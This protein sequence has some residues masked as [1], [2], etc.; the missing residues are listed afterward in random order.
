MQ[1]TKIVPHLPYCEGRFGSNRGHRAN[2][3]NAPFC[4]PMIQSR[5]TAL[6]AWPLWLPFR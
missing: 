5:P 1:W 2:Q 4:V 3:M 6:S